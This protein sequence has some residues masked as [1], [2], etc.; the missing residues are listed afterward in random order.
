MP[1]I[2]LVAL[3]FLLKYL[4]VG[5]LANISW[6]WPVGLAVFAF[7]WFEYFERI[8]GLDKRKDHQHFEKIKKE[9]VKRTFEKKK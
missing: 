4:E 9:R 1:L 5:F 3:L 6:W 7:L 2:I 8:L